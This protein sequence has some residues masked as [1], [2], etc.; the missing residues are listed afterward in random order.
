MRELRIACAVTVALALLAL[1]GAPPSEARLEGKVVKLGGI[2][3]ITGK[4][5]EWGEHSKIA[6]DIALEEIN[7]AGGVGGVK[8]EVVVHD[9]ATE[10]GQA[11]SLTRKLVLEEK[12][13]AIN[14]PCFS[15]EYEALAPLLD[16]LQIV[17]VSQCSS[18]PGLA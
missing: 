13:L 12:V 1:V 15:S 9:T 17:I 5:A 4:G 10:V 11:I 2:Y 6:T 14:G 8:L 7:A 16:R 3:P 18:K